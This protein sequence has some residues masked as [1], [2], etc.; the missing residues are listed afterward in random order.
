MSYS[1]KKKGKKGRISIAWPS[2]EWRYSVRGGK[3]GNG[4]SQPRGSWFWLDWCEAPQAFKTRREALGRWKKKK[5][6]CRWNS[7]GW[8]RSGDFGKEKQ[9]KKQTEEGG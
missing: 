9:N 4:S 2:A 1:Y 7:S 3:R 8:S 6:S 5:G